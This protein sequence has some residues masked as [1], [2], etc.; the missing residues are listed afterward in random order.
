MTHAVFAL[1]GIGFLVGFRHAFEPD[2]LAAVS[3]LASRHGWRTASGLGVAWGF[4]HTAS[5]GL[6]AVLITALGIR[7]PAAFFRSAEFGVAILLVTLGVS[8]LVIEARRHRR[9]QGPAHQDAHVHRHPHSHANL[10]TARSAFGFGIAHGLA[11]SGAVM[12]LIVAAASTMA[13]QIVYLV[14][15]GVGTILGMSVVSVL[16]GAVSGLASARSQRVGLAIR[17]GAACASTVVGVW[18]GAG[19]LSGA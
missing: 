11:G 16:T 7:V 2:H 4:G 17:L 6:V 3:T 18:L 9:Q 19:V 13:Q 8:T 14:V 5:V 15:F 12:V 1:I 10:R